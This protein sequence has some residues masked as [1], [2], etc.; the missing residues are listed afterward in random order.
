[1]VVAPWKGV[2]VGEGSW[3]LMPPGAAADFGF[4]EQS[5]SRSKIDAV[6]AGR[7]GPWGEF[8]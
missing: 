4:V 8:L 1:M 7:C 3:G 2:G 5:I 6:T